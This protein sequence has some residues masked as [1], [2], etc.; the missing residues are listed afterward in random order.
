MQIELG[1][2]VNV[3]F[4]WI[5]CVH[6]TYFLSAIRERGREH[7]DLFRMCNICVDCLHLFAH[8]YLVQHLVAL[9]ED[10]HL[11]FV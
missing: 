7:H 9:V 10:K 5:F 1:I 4:E 11:K 2:V 8:V 3:V 6:L